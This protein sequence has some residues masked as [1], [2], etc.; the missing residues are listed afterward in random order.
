MVSVAESIAPYASLAGLRVCQ[1]TVL[2]PETHTPLLRQYGDLTYAVL[3]PWVEGPTWL[4]ILVKEH[5]LSPDVSLA[6]ARSLADILTSMEQ[7]RLA[8]CDLSAP[9]VLVPALAESPAGDQESSIA[10]VDVEQLYGPRLQRPELLPSGSLGYA[11]T[12]AG[13]GQWGP[14]ADRFAGAVLLAEMLAWRDQRVREAAWGESYFRP[15]EL[16]QDSDRYRILRDALR[17]RWGAGVVGLLDRAWQ[18]RTL[19]NCATFG[20]WMATLPE[21]PQATASSGPASE[22][23]R[24]ERTPSD[25]RL[26]KMMSRG[27][28]LAREGRPAEALEAY[29]QAQE[30]APVGS[31]AAKELAQIVEGLEVDREEPSGT[32]LAAP[33]TFGEEE[34]PTV[35]PQDEEVETAAEEPGSTASTSAL[36]A[37]LALIRE[38][39]GAGD[40]G[41]GAQ[42]AE[43]PAVEGETEPPHGPQDGLEEEVTPAPEA[44]RR[45]EEER[46][47]EAAASDRGSTDEGAHAAKPPPPPTADGSTEP[48]RLFEH[49]MA[50]YRGERWDEARELLEDVVRR[51]PEYAQAGRKASALLAE[52]EKELAPTDQHAAKWI[53]ILGGLGL[54]AVVVTVVVGTVV[55]GGSQPEPVV[56]TRVVEVPITSTPQPVVATRLLEV[57]AT[58]QATHTPE[59]TPTR[60]PTSSSATAS[61]GDPDLYDDFDN[62][63]YDSSFDRSQ[64]VLWADSQGEIGQQDGVL[65]ASL[66]IQSDTSAGVTL[67]AREYD[68]FELRELAADGAI[69]LEAKLMLSEDHHAGNVQLHLGADLENDREW[70]SECNVMGYEDDSVWARCFDTRWPWQDEYGYDAKEKRVDLGTWHKVRIELD[71]DSMAFTYFIDGQSV[72]SHIPADADDLRE[73]DFSI[74]VGVWGPSSGRVTGYIDDV[75][76][77]KVEE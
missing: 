12:A 17:D 57:T 23:D 30:L 47:V 6:L 22:D 40:A 26:R 24:E 1:R 19:A 33:R 9:N 56:E 16:Q 62:L 69:F 53:G 5:P 59:L 66:D 32:G 28:R 64:W 65:M 21:K 31:K 48:D 34:R 37:E 71:P 52:T 36:E 7:R 67:G 74:S 51:Q 55:F 46:V 4:E 44:G 58:P 50:A 41:S 54:V 76:I 70:F 13:D 8:H 27:D 75:R 39:E 60:P 2:T 72:G 45:G 63:S 25:D 73:A 68:G 61:D 11:H 77:G 10:L 35:Q 3:M 29:K 43:A 49:A 20:E 38:R 15:D 18:S 14:R 42:Q